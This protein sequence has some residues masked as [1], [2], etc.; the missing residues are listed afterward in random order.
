MSA[1]FCKVI[2]TNSLSPKSERANVASSLLETAS[3]R[4]TLGWTSSRT[5]H[6][7]VR[8]AIVVSP[9][10]FGEGGAE[11]ICWMGVLKDRRGL[12]DGLKVVRSL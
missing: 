9:R 5:V 10:S 11:T 8:T 4:L 12:T 3:G 6:P 1:A 7:D 2:S